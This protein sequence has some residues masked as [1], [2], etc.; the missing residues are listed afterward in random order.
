MGL[1]FA[2]KRVNYWSFFVENNNNNNTEK[3]VLKRYKHEKEKTDIRPA[4]LDIELETWCYISVA[5]Q[6]GT[7]GSFLD[8]GNET[9]GYTEQTPPPAAINLWTDVDVG[10][11]LC[12]RRL[13]G[14]KRETKIALAEFAMRL[15]TWRGTFVFSFSYV[16]VALTF[17]IETLAVVDKQ[18]DCYVVFVLCIC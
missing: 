16:Q 12:P 11:Q 17:I 9:Q 10:K 13:F 7:G 8:C 2:C 3:L 4:A 5:N 15:P 14:H 18:R 1:L 6:N